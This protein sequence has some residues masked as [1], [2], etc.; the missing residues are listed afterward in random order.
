MCICSCTK[1]P[2]V[3]ASPGCHS[4]LHPVPWPK[5]SVFGVPVLSTGC[6]FCANTALNTLPMASHWFSEV[7]SWNSFSS[8]PPLEHPQRWLLSKLWPCG[9]AFPKLESSTPL[10][11]L[12]I[13]LMV[14]RWSSEHW[15][16]ATEHSQAKGLPHF[17]VTWQMVM[18]AKFQQ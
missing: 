15:E 12:G 14:S 2:L 6:C 16:L 17:L 5:Q 11:A 18:S 1:F 3:S 13:R 9:N 8:P 7:L 10:P 4:L